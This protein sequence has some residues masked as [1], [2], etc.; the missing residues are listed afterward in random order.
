M[1]HESKIKRNIKIAYI[2]SGIKREAISIILINR[3]NYL[4]GNENFEIS[5][6]SEHDNDDSLIKSFRKEVKL[7][8]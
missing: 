3:I 8:L 4:I 1:H 6:I 5:V 2:I 7:Y